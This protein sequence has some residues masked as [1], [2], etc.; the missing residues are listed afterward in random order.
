MEDSA[1]RRHKEAA[2]RTAAQELDSLLIKCEEGMGWPRREPES[3]ELLKRY[4][5]C[6]FRLLRPSP[7][8]ISIWKPISGRGKREK[9]VDLCLLY[10]RERNGASA[11][12]VGCQRR[13]GIGRYQTVFRGMGG[14]LPKESVGN[15]FA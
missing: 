3:V 15:T 9:P 11:G 10:S 8:R 12:N 14:S 7:T 5:G 6:P 2:Q 13:S 1:K 4:L